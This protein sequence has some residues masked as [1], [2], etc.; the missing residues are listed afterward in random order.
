MQASPN[1]VRAMMIGFASKSSG[2]K[3]TSGF[4]PFCRLSSLMFRF[5]QLVRSRREQWQHWQA[6][7]VA[8]EIGEPQAADRDRT[9]DGPG[10]SGNTDAW[11]KNRIYMPPDIH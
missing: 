2:S 4:L 1:P 9:N 6:S 8:E 11:I 7:Q 5:Q 3:L 10:Q